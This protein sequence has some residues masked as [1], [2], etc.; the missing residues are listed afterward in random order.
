MCI[1]T[2]TSVLDHVVM[3]SDNQSILLRK[4]LCSTE[5]V[6]RAQS[7]SWATRVPHCAVIPRLDGAFRISWQ[8]TSYRAVADEEGIRHLIL[9]FLPL[10]DRRRNVKSNSLGMSS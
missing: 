9:A 5:D 7:E 4:A 3:L 8:P 1:R 2:I 10:A 6:T